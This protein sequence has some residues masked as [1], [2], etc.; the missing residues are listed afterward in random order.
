[1]NAEMV[2][3]L[4]T[5]FSLLEGELLDRRQEEMTRLVLTLER[6]TAEIMQTS[7]DLTIRKGKLGGT[8]ATND[9][10]CIA[11]QAKLD[12]L[13]VREKQLEELYARQSTEVDFLRGRVRELLEPAGA[14]SKAKAKRRSSSAA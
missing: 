12:Q 6:L 11:L 14:T 10:E 5:S 2:Y 13:E 8:S 9:P 3:R 7:G 4:D 1:M